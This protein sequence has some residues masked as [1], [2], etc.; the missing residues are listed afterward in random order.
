[1]ADQAKQPDATEAWR[2][3]TAKATAKALGD[4]LG[5]HYYTQTAATCIV[6]RQPQQEVQ[7]EAD[8]ADAT[9]TTT[10]T[11]ENRRVVLRQR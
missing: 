8:S 9:T 1:M 5:I 4:R 10:T 11:A 2:A 3:L 6:Q 7:Q